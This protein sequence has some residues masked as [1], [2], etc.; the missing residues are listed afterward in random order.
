MPGQAYTNLLMAQGKR[1]ICHSAYYGL[2]C[3][4]WTFENCCLYPQD[5][6]E[7]LGGAGRVR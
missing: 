2:M 1:H 3:S 4:K 5:S 6:R 7:R